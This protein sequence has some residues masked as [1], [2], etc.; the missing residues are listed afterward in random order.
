MKK[1]V[2]SYALNVA[3]ACRLLIMRRMELIAIV[4]VTAPA[5]NFGGT[6]VHADITLLFSAAD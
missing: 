1:A 6:V 2:K 4:T 3:Q 5:E